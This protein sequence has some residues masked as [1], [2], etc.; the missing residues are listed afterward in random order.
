LGTYRG[1]TTITATG[2][3]I[4]G[5]TFVKVQYVEGALTSKKFYPG[6]S[7]LKDCQ[8]LFVGASDTGNEFM[9]YYDKCQINPSGDF[10]W[11]SD[12]FTK[13]QLMIDI[14]DDSIDNPTKPFGTFRHLGS[15]TNI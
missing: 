10:N 9:A 6:T 2:P 1:F 4:T 15:G 13:F 8:V 3:T 14:L 7:I 11:S 5:P 12:D